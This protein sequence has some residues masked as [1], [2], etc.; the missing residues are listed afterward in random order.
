MQKKLIH[1]LTP[2]VI[3]CGM[4]RSGTSFVARILSEMG[5]FMGND[6]EV[7]H[8][9]LSFLLLN[10]KLLKLAHSFWDEIRGAQYFFQDQ[11]AISQATELIEKKFFTRRFLKGYLGKRTLL[12]I[13][14]NWGWKDPR[15]TITLPL[16]IN[17]F[18]DA[19]VIFIYRNGVDSAAS[20]VK[21]ENK[22][23]FDI[24]IPA[25]SSRCGDLHGAFGL[26]KDYN[27]F[28][29]NHKKQFASENLLEIKYEDCLKSPEAFLDQLSHFLNKNLTQQLRDTIFKEIN[30]DRAYSFKGDK[31]LE[32]FYNCVKE[33]EIMMELG[34]KYLMD[35]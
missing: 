13:P 1:K 35:A 2:P 11:Q 7:N 18:K 26:W 19:K 21:R 29:L 15:N 31:K 16:W 14:Q 17:V 6:T 33:D 4:H 3:V 32:D 27:Q 30:S 10:D 28:F 9:S 24:T 34:Y 5:I 22:Q 23:N 8:E 20:L 25:Y 12:D